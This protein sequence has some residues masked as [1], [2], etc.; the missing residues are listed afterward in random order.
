MIGK[1]L[2]LQNFIYLIINEDDGMYS[3]KCVKTGVV[4]H[5]LKVDI[6]YGL[7]ENKIKICTTLGKLLY[8]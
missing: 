5:V 8:S 4:Y 2:L 3:L 7:S 1:Y 6:T